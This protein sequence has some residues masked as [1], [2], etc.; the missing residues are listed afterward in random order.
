MV[1]SVHLVAYLEFAYW[2]KRVN[3]AGWLTL[4]IFPYREDGVR[5]ASECRSW[6][7]ALFAAL[8][9]VGMEAFEEVIK[10]AD[11]TR[12]SALVRQALNLGA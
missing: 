8:D 10:E 4:D 5:A 12:A 3:Y 7:A 9:R 6:M 2:L 11:A 1:G